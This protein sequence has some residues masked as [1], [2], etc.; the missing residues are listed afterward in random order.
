MDEPQIAAC[1]RDLDGLLMAG[2]NEWTHA[3]WPNRPH[4]N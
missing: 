2:G 4:R 3:F 1:L